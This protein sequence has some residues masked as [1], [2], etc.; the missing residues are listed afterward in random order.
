MIS[1]IFIYAGASKWFDKFQE[2][3]KKF[4]LKV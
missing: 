4:Q 2:N 3:R 1:F